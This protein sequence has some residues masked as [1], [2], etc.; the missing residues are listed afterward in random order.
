MKRLVILLSLVALLPCLALAQTP[1]TAGERKE[2]NLFFS[3]FA[4]AN[5]GDFDQAT[6]SDE[7]MLRLATW[8]CIMH[9]DPS[10]KRVNKGNSIVIPSSV[11]DSI[12]QASLGR[13]VSKH[14]RE[15]YVESLASGEAIVFAQVASLSPHGDGT[16]QAAGSIYYASS[17]DV[18]DQHATRAQWKR[19]KADVRLWGTFTGVIKREQAPSPHWILLQYRVK[20]G[21]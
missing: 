20:E 5:L 12:T 7:D 1:L 17:G 16:F 21:K 4:A 10:L 3:D 8:R 2:L 6:I 19:A 15:R 9:P 18:F 11:I 14:T 13:T